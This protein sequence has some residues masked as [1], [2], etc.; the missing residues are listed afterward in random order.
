MGNIM[1]RSVSLFILWAF[2]AYSYA[3]YPV[4]WDLTSSI[5]EALLQAPQ[6]EAVKAEIEAR[7]NQLEEVDNW[8]NPRLEI[9]IDDTVSLE[10]GGDGY[11]F[12]QFDIIQP[13]PIGRLDAETRQARVALTV[14]QS[15]QRYNL[16]EVEK[17]TANVFYTLQY[18][19]DLLTLAEKKHN[20]LGQLLTVNK[21]PLVRYF[22]RM[23]R[24]RL[25]ILREE[26]HQA[27]AAAEGEYQEAVSHFRVLLA[28]PET[29]MPAI[30]SIQSVPTPQQLDMLL[31][32]LEQHPLLM[33]LEQS[34]TVA[35]TGIEIARAQRRID[36]E[37]KLFSTRDVYA[38][39]EQTSTGVSLMF[40]IPLWQ[41]SNRKVT[42]ARA[43]FYQ[44][45]AELKMQQRELNSRLRRNRLHLQHL[46][47]QAKHYSEHILAPAQEILQLSQSGYR[48]G[49]IDLLHFIDAHNTY[50]DAQARHLRLIYE[51]WLET[52][53]LRYNA[54]QLLTEVTP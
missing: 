25:G 22:P 37:L 14:V 7:Q 29:H 19:T 17:T 35:E 42:R 9:A 11:A 24:K 3:Q 21:D 41:N 34:K 18:R 1:T 32:S 31:A 44:Q 5:Q 30:D 26:A 48:S 45:Q 46:I 15:Q 38:G 2:A 4:Q 43:D 12:S 47:E 40:E 54:G 51:G 36:P 23:E 52:A 13:L 49:E 39:R 6:L 16:L 33:S 20:S 50:Y 27:M 53:E 10:Q 8:P 28:L